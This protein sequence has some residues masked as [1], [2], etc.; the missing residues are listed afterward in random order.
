[1]KKP[2]RFEIEIAGRKLAIEV[3]KYAGQADGSCT[4]QYGDTVVLATVSKGGVRPEIDY[5]PLMVDYEER[6]YAAGKIKG[7]RFVKREGRP[8]DEAVLTGRLVD[9]AI[10]PL[11]D[12]SIRH[13]VQV[14]LTVLS[15]DQENDPDFPSLIAA[16][17]ALMISSIPWGGPIAGMQMSYLENAWI[18]NAT[19]E[20]KE[21]AT[22]NIFI[23]G[24][25]EK[26]NMMEADAKEAP[27]EIVGAGIE[28]GLSEL[29]PILELIGEVTKTCG[30]EK[31]IPET[32][33][34]TDE[35]KKRQ[36]DIVNVVDP[37]VKKNFDRI[38]N[39]ADK[40]ELSTAL[41]SVKA[42]LL[43]IFA[44]QEYAD[45]DRAFAT[46]A[47]EEAYAKEVARMV[48]ETGKRV[49]GRALDE[50]RP[51]SAEVAVLPR[52]HGSGLFAR[53]E[54]QI[55]SVVT[56]GSPG[57]EQLL[58]EMELEGK[59]RFFH[60]YNFPPFSVG[61]VKPLRGPGRR[62]IGHGALVEKALLA[63]IPEKE[64]FPYTIRIVSEALSSNGST[65]QASIVA[66]S[67]ALLDAGVPMKKPV[68][69]ISI[70]LFSDEARGAY[71]TVVDIQGIEDHSGDMDFKIAGTR[72]GITAIQYDTKI[73]GIP[74]AVAI[75][76]LTKARAARFQILD[77]MATTIPTHRAELSVYAPR[78]EVLHI[79]PE[80][81][82]DLIGPGGKIINKIIEQT[83]VA[84]DI[85]D[86][87]TVFVTSENAEMMKK[88]LGLI[89]Q[90]TREIMIGEVYEGKVTQIM[91]DRNTG[92]EIGAIVEIMPGRD[93]MVHISEIAWER[94]P[95]VSDR[96]NVG[97]AVKVKVVDVD[98]ERGRIGL[99]IKALLERPQGAGDDHG[100]SGRSSGFSHGSRDRRHSPHGGFRDRSGRP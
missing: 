97:D 98:K 91:K 3:G 17:T 67:L 49:D 23:S 90:I 54:T 32:L 75:E 77:L 60:H 15:V 65:S 76:A 61:E 87:G 92:S 25:P 2:Q 50:L 94:I 20:Q 59:K 71:K 18:L 6:L 58:D 44:S 38:S 10:R 73:A 24:T 93:G 21:K 57:D 37:F 79:D 64:A 62:E 22:A 72:D 36:Q 63:M 99:S 89:D 27:E 28:Q 30:K 11:F 84:I 51:L 35:H 39:I 69:G 82:G 5:F 26:L 4:V 12:Q 48:L 42:E 14:I 13:D 34:V 7:A 31:E 78:I 80:K 43:K 81:I 9:R 33:V 29:K 47:F 52:T 53:G 16:S 45:H 100:F 40:I 74:I 66:S 8:T 96:V 70:G 85:E 95:N 41:K 46:D 19:Y 86:D 68:A 83:E 55:L 1:M 88:A 56:L